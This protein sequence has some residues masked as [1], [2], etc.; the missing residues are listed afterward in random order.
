MLGNHTSS[1]SKAHN[2]EPQ[3]RSNPGN[4]AARRPS[5]R[6]DSSEGASRNDQNIPP[7]EEISLDGFADSLQRLGQALADADV[8]PQCIPR[9]LTRFSAERI[10][11]NLKLYHQRAPSVERPGAWLY[12]AITQGY[13]LPS[14]CQRDS[15]HGSKSSERTEGFLPE[16]GTKVSKNRKQALIRKGLATEE[17]FDKFADYYDPDRKQH[18]YRLEKE[19][20]GG[21]R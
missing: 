9:L 17:D 21:H 10:E 6:T 2:P 1:D 4:R 5:T 7:D 8:R 18:F 16:P 12:S 13:A 14:S 20:T 19:T 3:S 15:P 11:A